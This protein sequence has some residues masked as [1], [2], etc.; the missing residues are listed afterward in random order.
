[1]YALD[2]PARC[3]THPAHRRKVLQ[4]LPAAAAAWELSPTHPDKLPLTTSAASAALRM[5]ARLP[6]TAREAQSAAA[7]AQLRL[8]AKLA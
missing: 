7:P 3:H 6:P 2:S 8:V 4:G 5:V 1:M